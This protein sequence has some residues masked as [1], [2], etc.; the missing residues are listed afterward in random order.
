M[1]SEGWPIHFWTLGGVYD[2][3]GS[4]AAVPVVEFE[5]ANKCSFE[6]D[7][8]FEGAEEARDFDFGLFGKVVDEETRFF[9]V[10]AV[11]ELCG[12]VFFVEEVFGH[13]LRKGKFRRF[14][15]GIYGGGL[16]RLIARFEDKDG[17]DTAGEKDGNEDDGNV[18]R[19]AVRLGVR[20]DGRVRVGCFFPGEVFGFDGNG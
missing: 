18:V 2:K 4:L 17:E 5:G 1:A 19:G 20:V 8:A 10:S 14:R 9:G 6:G 11:G 12:R 16:S 3:D 7:L 13:F 15:D